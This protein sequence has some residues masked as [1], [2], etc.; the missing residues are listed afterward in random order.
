M[1]EFEPKDYALR[2]K[3]VKTIA[4]ADTLFAD[5]GKLPATDRE[6]ALDAVEA[7]VVDDFT[8]NMGPA[9]KAQLKMALDL[10]D[11][12]KGTPQGDMLR[13]QMES[14]DLAEEG[15]ANAQV[16]LHL[17]NTRGDKAHPVVKAFVAEAA[18]LSDEELA[19]TTGLLKVVVAVSD[20]VEAENKP[21]ARPNPFRKSGGAKP[22]AP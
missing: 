7:Y 15:Q 21:V 20:A 16:M 13:A 11:Q 22:F 4:D 19:S 9:Q 14:P 1:S 2:V 6:Q 17:H 5:I 3:G 18:K 8:L 10:L 12:L